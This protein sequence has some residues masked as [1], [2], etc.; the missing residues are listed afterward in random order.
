MFR[1]NNT[2]Q[3]ISGLPTIIL[4]YLDLKSL[5]NLRQVNQEWLRLINKH[6]HSLPDYTIV[7][8]AI[9]G[10]LGENNQ[11][12]NNQADYSYV[13]F[14]FKDGSVFTFGD[15][16]LGQLGL[17]DTVSRSLPT[18]VSEVSFEQEQVIQS[19]ASFCLTLFLG[20]KGNMFVCGS[21]GTGPSI[22]EPYKLGT[23]NSIF[24]DKR[25]I[26]IRTNHDLTFYLCQDGTV[27]AYGSNQCRQLGLNNFIS[28][29]IPT[30]IDSEHFLGKKVI[31]SWPGP[32][33]SFFLCDDNSIFRLGGLNA[34]IPTQV[35][36][37]VFENKEIVQCVVGFGHCIFICADGSVFTLGENPDGQLGHN[38]VLDRF[39]PVRIDN[40]HFAGRK[41]IQGAAGSKHSIFV[42]DDGSVYS[43]GGNS[44]GQLAQENIRSL[45]PVRINDTY[46]EGRR[47]IQSVCNDFSTLFIC[48]NSVVY[49]CG[50]INGTSIPQKIPN[51][52]YTPHCEAATISALLLK[53]V[54]A[55]NALDPEFAGILG[56]EVKQILTNTA[57]YP[58][59]PSALCRAVN[60]LNKGENLVE[61]TETE[62]TETQKAQPVFL[63]LFNA[64]KGHIEAMKEH[65]VKKIRE[66]EDEVLLIGIRQ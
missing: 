52:L 22:E 9:G 21:D 18:R 58:A 33:L 51:P 15:N 40:V 41:V 39:M 16:A 66:F 64:A 5:L 54:T 57:F 65:A 46:F 43:C 45:I 12:E 31:Q 56:N 28:T 50:A 26:Q 34:A 32:I 59:I 14:V 42:C 24:K 19:A 49:A 55:L 2:V 1:Q 38:D 30:R 13:V 8:C 11:E 62:K 48:E 36:K 6:V 35:D 47:V 27:Y 37:A 25:I 44:R 3:I 7:D 4:Q 17:G 61:I 23:A 60:I 63:P 20:S 10:Y 53:Q 29:N